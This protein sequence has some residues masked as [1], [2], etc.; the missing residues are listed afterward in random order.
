M[1]FRLTQNVRLRSANRGNANLTWFV[2][3]SGNVGNYNANNANR[4]C[5][6]VTAILQKGMCIARVQDKP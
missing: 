3:S 5:P 4:F 6:I 2:S 1:G